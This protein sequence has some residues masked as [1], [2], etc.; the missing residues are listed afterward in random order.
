[1]TSEQQSYRLQ[2]E[3]HVGGAERAV[4]STRIISR[5]SE[6][7]MSLSKRLIDESTLFSGGRTSSIW[8]NS[9]C[10]MD[11][12]GGLT[13]KASLLRRKLHDRDRAS[14]FR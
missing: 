1:V 7:L 3:L 6:A 14:L 13:R 9:V 4:P 12:F 2:S 11:L 8:R 5:E 10:A